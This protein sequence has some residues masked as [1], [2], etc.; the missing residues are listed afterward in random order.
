MKPIDPKDKRTFEL[1]TN[2]IKAGGN[3]T[4]RPVQAFCAKYDIDVLELQKNVQS[5][6]WTL[7]RKKLEQLNMI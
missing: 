4:L 5:A 7:T 3:V 6:S 2:Y 1:V